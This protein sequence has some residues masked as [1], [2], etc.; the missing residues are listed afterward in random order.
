MSNHFA[1]A[2]KVWF[3]YCDGGSHQGYRK[4][5]INYKGVNIYFKGHII[6]QNQLDDL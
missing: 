2:T 3:K 1:D 4:T 5:P 6:T